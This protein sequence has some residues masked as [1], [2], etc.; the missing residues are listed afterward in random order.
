MSVFGDLPLRVRL[1]GGFGAPA[2]CLAAV[3]LLGSAPD[4]RIAALLGLIVTV[5][6]AVLLS[7]SLSRRLGVV[8]ARLRSLRDA[9]IA[10]IRAGLV[11][12]AAGDLTCAYRLKT[13][14]ISDS[15]HDE[16]GRIADAIDAIRLT[17][18]ACLEG[19]N[20]TCVARGKVIANLDEA[21]KE[22]VSASTQMAATSQEF[23]L[24]TD[25]IADSVSG[26]AAGAQRQVDAVER[27]RL[28]AEEVA[29]ATTEAAANIE[30]TAEVTQQAREA[31]R[32]GSGAAEEAEEAMR[33][34]RESSGEVSSVMQELAQKSDQIGV[35]VNTI[36]GIAEQTNLLA[37]NAAIEAA[38]AGEQ[39]RGFSVVA[40][41]VRKLA[42]GAQHAAREITELIG[43]I[44]RQTVS[45]VE[46][47]QTG[48]RRTEQG[49]SVF[50]R[51]REAFQHID[52]SVSDMSTRIDQIAA[53]SDE[54]AA[55]VHSMQEH[56]HAVAQ[57]A[58]ESSS[59]TQRVSATTEHSSAA[60]QHI[61]ASAQDLC[62][63]A[64]MLSQFV[65]RF[66][67]SR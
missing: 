24:A 35:I 58:R 34:V 37:L 38:R 31:A 6:V 25:A 7:T 4:E 47:V 63:N 46:V 32:R 28:T 64:A 42:E 41:E 15:R 2:A 43:A 29:R 11:A 23:G 48:A 8:E 50:A 5:P 30:A 20:A 45:A 57:V 16:L 62:E 52:A 53:I 13:V 55:S 54:I 12:L 40:E 9:D 14:P 33:S 67:L 17:V 39:G 56:M 65:A 61:T 22:V 19:H 26:I 66:T 1:F 36:T 59:A 27:A 49:T 60:V 3:I 44:Q 10:S 21:A 51:T 18:E